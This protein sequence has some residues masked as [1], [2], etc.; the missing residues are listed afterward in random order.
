[1]IINISYDSSITSSTYA[2][3]I[4]LAIQTAVDFYEQ[5]FSNPITINIDFGYGE[6]NGTA[7]TDSSHIAESLSIGNDFSYSQVKSALAANAQTLIDQVAVAALPGSDP[8]GGGNFYIARAEQKALGLISGNDNT[9]D[10]YV[11]LSSA[12]TFWL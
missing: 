4:E 11:G 2:V 5:T 8:T 1:M 9:I 6:V 12:F 10:G 3:N 7:I